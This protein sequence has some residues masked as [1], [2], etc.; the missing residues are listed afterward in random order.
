MAACSSAL[1]FSCVSRSYSKSLCLIRVD[2][3]SSFG[4]AQCASLLVTLP[5]SAFQVPS[6]FFYPCFPA[7]VCL[8]D[9][10]CVVGAPERLF[11]PASP[12]QQGS[13]NSSVVHT[14]F[15]HSRIHPWTPWFLHLLPC[16]LFHEF[17]QSSLWAKKT[18]TRNFLMFHNSSS[19]TQN[20]RISFKIQFSFS[21]I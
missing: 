11:P 21:E 2:V 15:P 13:A 3:L 4:R 9:R 14:A 7:W 5:S 17:S 16:N 20:T 10:T 18:H 19:Q 1:T 12:V 6:L 8:F